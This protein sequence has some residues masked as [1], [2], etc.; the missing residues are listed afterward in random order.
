MTARILSATDRRMRIGLGERYADE[1]GPGAKLLHR[2][3]FLYGRN[4]GRNAPPAENKLVQTPIGRR[5]SGWADRVAERCG[6]R[7]EWLSGT[8]DGSSGGLGGR[9]ERETDRVVER[10]EGWIGGRADR[11]A[12][13]VMLCRGAGDE[14]GQASQ[15]I[16][17]R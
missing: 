5:E 1:S 9:A 8:G 7:S 2:G 15:A 3:F 13:H 11:V 12:E 14:A 16:G 17:K 10:V 4:A 6:W